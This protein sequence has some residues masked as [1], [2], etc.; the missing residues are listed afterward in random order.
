MDE[1]TAGTLSSAPSGTNGSSEQS[2]ATTEAPVWDQATNTTT[3]SEIG[4]Q[5][6]TQDQSL[7]YLEYATA[8]YNFLA[9]P[10]GTGAPAENYILLKFFGAQ[11]TSGEYAYYFA[12]SVD[13]VSAWQLTDDNFMFAGAGT[14]FNELTASISKDGN[15][16]FNVSAL[17]S[18]LYYGGQAT[19]ASVSTNDITINTPSIKGVPGASASNLFFANEP[20]IV[21]NNS[22][23]ASRGSTT[24]SSIASN[25]L[26]VASAP[27][28]TD[29]DDVIV[30]T[31][32]ADTL[33]TLSPIS[34]KSST[35]YMAASGTASGS[36]F[37]SGNLVTVQ[38]ADIT[39]N[40]DI[41]TPGLQDLT[42]SVYPSS[43]YIIG[44]DVAITGS[45]TL[46][47]QPNQLSSASRF[48]DQDL[49]AI[50][51]QVDNGSDQYIR[52]FMPYC[53]VTAVTGGDLVATS[54]VSFTVVKGAGT[55][56]L[57]RFELKYDNA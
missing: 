29:A 40:R 50:G 20:I 14:I 25:V 22:G 38:S 3:F 15:L 7:N 56:D 24:V 21:Y 18:R 44:N 39:I 26:T 41:Q 52:F 45:F 49:M 34:M 47:A 27:A 2:F 31:I 13:T 9:K 57:S 10:N 37:A 43:A 6:L 55:T 4:S 19:V 1:S 48:V 35:V 32:S 33:S 36:L 11:N 53:R 12:N 30:P 42:G 23:G 28:S 16:I 46:N 54:T 51:I 17:A 8:S 5:I